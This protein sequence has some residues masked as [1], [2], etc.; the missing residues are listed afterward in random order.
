MYLKK[1]PRSPD[2]WKSSW[3]AFPEPE[4]AIFEKCRVGNDVKP[5]F[6]DVLKIDVQVAPPSVG[7]SVI[8]RRPSSEKAASIVDRET[9]TEITN[10]FSS[11]TK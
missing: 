3:T 11:G 2:R 8:A 9:E 6:D 10:Y 5:K 4:C 7:K 1:F